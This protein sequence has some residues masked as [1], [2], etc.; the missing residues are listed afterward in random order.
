RSWTPLVPLGYGL[1]YRTCAYSK[2]R[3]SA[4]RIVAGDSLTVSVDVKNTG[5]RAG[6]EVVQLYLR[7]GV[8]SVAEAVKSLK[9][10]RRVTL[11]PAETRTVMFRIGADAFSLYNRQMR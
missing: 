4:P 6:D 8:A 9:A 7:D 2:L 3:L 5:N 10:F 11:Q 1:S